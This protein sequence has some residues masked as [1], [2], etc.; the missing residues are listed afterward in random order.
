MPRIVVI[1]KALGARVEAVAARTRQANSPYYKVNPSGRVPYLVRDDGIGMEGS[2]VICAYLD[3]VNG[4]PTF[5]VP[6]GADAWEAPRLLASA[7]STLEGLAVW[8]RELRRPEHERSAAAIT[9]ETARAVRM[10]DVWEQWVE[11]PLLAGPLNMLQITLG[12]ALGLERRLPS[13]Q[14]HSSHPRLYKWY[15]AVSRR[16][17]FVATQ[18]PS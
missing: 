16:P 18:P 1:E 11:H 4:T 10:F 13:L 6:A 14:W 8:A 2:A 3:Q 7:Q 17:S 9:H 5:S 12:C 15:S